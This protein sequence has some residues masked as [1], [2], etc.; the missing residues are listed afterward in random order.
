M[1]LVD[2]RG[3]IVHANASGHTLLAEKLVLRATDGKLAGSDADAEQSLH[4][5]FLAAGCGDMVLGTKDI[6]VPLTASDGQRWVAHVC[7]SRAGSGGGP[8]RATRQ[9]RPCSCTRRRWRHRRR[10]R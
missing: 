1:I 7:R 5:I 10:W 6:A 3:R 2:G 9:R 4:E 8:V